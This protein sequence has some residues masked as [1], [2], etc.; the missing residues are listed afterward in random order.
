MPET[1]LHS[2]SQKNIRT[3]PEIDLYLMQ[4]VKI[5]PSK[6]GEVHQLDIM[7][8]IDSAWSEKSWQDELENAVVVLLQDEQKHN[9]GFLAVS[10]SGSDLEIRKIGILTE[11]RRKGLGSNL[12]HH[13]LEIG[14]QMMCERVLLDVAVK[15]KAAID[16][17]LKN[18]FIELGHRRRYYRNGDDALLL[19][20]TYHPQHSLRHLQS[21]L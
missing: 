14:K 4:F 2:T 9:I 18:G 6:A 10:Q 20:F 3:V 16:F 7:I 15:N 5:E 11:W 13:C 1:D 17:Y 21:N 12:L 8:F 19:V